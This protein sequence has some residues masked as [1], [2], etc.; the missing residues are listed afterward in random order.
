MAFS[1][2]FACT[3]L[4]ILTDPVFISA[5]QA[6]KTN[7]LHMKRLFFVSFFFSI[8]SGGCKAIRRN[9]IMENA[10]IGDALILLG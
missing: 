9:I 4:P 7:Q 2:E 3:F 10:I 6:Q 5:Y 8:G 1:G